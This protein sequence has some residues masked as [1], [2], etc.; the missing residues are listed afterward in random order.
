MVVTLLA[1]VVGIGLLVL[2]AAAATRHGVRR[3]RTADGGNSG[4]EMSWLG[5]SSA[6]DSSTADGAS[7]ADCGGGVDGGSC[8]DGGGGGSD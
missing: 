5:G 1:L 7:G 6:G 3:T 8:G 2:L 4:G